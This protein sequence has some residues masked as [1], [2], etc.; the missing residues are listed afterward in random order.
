MSRFILVTSVIGAAVNVGLNLFMI[1]RWGV[2]G[3]LIASSFSFALTTFGLEW[4]DRRASD[5]LRLMA[6]AMARPWRSYRH[7]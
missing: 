2:T 4:M 7:D 3:A 1:P 5:N 6:A